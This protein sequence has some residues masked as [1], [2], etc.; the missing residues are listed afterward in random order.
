MGEDLQ[1]REATADDVPAIAALLAAEGLPTFECGEDGARFRVI[2]D[3]ETIVAA[4]GIES[5][6]VDALLRSVVVAP[7][8]RQRGLARRLT[9]HLVREARDGGHRC[10]YLLT[11][12]ADGYFERLGFSAIDRDVAP[13]P[14]RLS[15]QFRSQ[16]PDSAV[17]MLRAL[18]PASS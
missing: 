11:M 2:V 5:H 12:D 7:E 18:A 15:D 1:L 8:H 4:A 6:G 14:I 9:E 13:E 17:L 3:G 10:M 16:C